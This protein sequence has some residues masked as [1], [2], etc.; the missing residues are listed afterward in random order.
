MEAVRSTASL[1]RARVIVGP[2]MDVDRFKACIASKH[3]RRLPESAQERATHVIAVAET[4]LASPLVD[5]VS[6]LLHEIARALDPQI[7]DRLGR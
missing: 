1:N 3:L 4:S 2:V 7:L 6:A 5:R